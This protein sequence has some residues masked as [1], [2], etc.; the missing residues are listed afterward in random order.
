[1]DLLLIIQLAP[2]L[3]RLVR[4][5]TRRLFDEPPVAKAIST[6]D[7]AFR[8]VEVAPALRRWCESPTFVALLGEVESG[9]EPPTEDDIV[10]SFISASDFYFEDQR[11]TREKAR[12]IVEA[13]FQTLHKNLLGRPEL[14]Y[15]DARTQQAVREG[16]QEIK[17]YLGEVVGPGALTRTASPEASSIEVAEREA[18]AKVDLARGLIDQGKVISAREILVTLREEVHD[19]EPSD[20]LLFRIAANLGACWLSL[21]QPEESEREY[22]LALELRPRD[23]RILAALVRCALQRGDLEKALELSTASLAESPR[24]PHAAATYVLALHRLNRHGELEKFVAENR[25]LFAD[26]VGA[27]TL[28]EIRLDQERYDDA[29]ALLRRALGGRDVD[30]PAARAMLA[31]AIVT[32]IQ[33]ALKLNPPVEGLPEEMDRGLAEGELELS[34]AIDA[35]KDQEVP[36]RLRDAVASR[37]GVRAMRGHLESALD[38]A[39]RVL[40]DDGEHRVALLNRAMVLLRLNKYADAS[41]ELEKL[42]ADSPGDTGLLLLLGVALAG[43]DRHREAVQRLEGIWDPASAD[44]IQAE[45]SDV[46]LRSAWEIRDLAKVERIAGEIRGSAAPSALTKAVLARHLI[47]EDQTEDAIHLLEEAQ[48]EAREQDRSRVNR[49]LAEAYLLSERYV[50]AVRTYSGFVETTRDSASLRSYLAALFN[51]GNY[52]LALELAQGVRRGGKA[53]PVVSEVEA[54]VLQ[55]I[56]DLNS[57]T[58]LFLELAQLE[59]NKVSHLID[60]AGMRLRQGNTEESKEILQSLPFEVI[61]DD[62]VQLLRLAELRLVLGERGVMELAYRARRLDFDNPYTHERYSFLFLNS[63]TLEKELLSVDEVK[64]DSAVRL[65]RGEESRVITVVDDDLTSLARGEVGSDD[66]LAQ[67]LLGK[68]VGDQAVLREGLEDLEYEVVEIQS[69]F[70]A[71]FQETLLN[72]S[73]WFPARYQLQRVEIRENDFSRIFSAIDAR[74]EFAQQVTTLYRTKPATLGVLGSLLG[75]STIDVW[76]GL[77]GMEETRFIVAEGN[78]G[79][80]QEAAAL[81]SSQEQL[82]VDL[83]SILTLAHL[84]LLERLKDRFERVTCPQSLLDT[85][86]EYVEVNYKGATPTG[87]LAKRGTSYIHVEHS[88]EDL[89]KARKHLEG[90]LDF[91]HHKAVVEPVREAL[92]LDPDKLRELGDLIGQDSLDSML[93]AKQFSALLFSDDLRL[94]QLAKGE[95]G[96]DSVWTQPLLSDLRTRGQ[97]TEDEYRRALTHLLLSDYVFISVSAEDLVHTLRAEAFTRSPRSERVLARALGSE[98][99][100]TSAVTAA[101]GVIKVVWLENLLYARK[102]VI[103]DLVLESLTMVRVSRRRVLEELVRALQASLNLL[104]VT[105]AEVVQNIDAWAQAHAL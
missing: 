40:L 5:G 64:V 63:E 60:A 17:Q 56:G 10:E 99:S 87:T 53:I 72:F 13:F 3:I 76:V 82:V 70:V 19:K 34:R 7:S 6:T 78:A 11:Q 92:E 59:S 75:C 46:L 89:E 49:E 58:R 29:E 98:T 54:R 79:E 14:V 69:K 18:Q 33:A 12:E 37:A 32:P 48:S 57:A 26:A 97:L 84:G 8:E 100:L 61:R 103:L 1:M 80:V 31:V 77:V 86:M 66:V 27:G 21:G 30:T 81:L 55:V 23:P 43:S 47:R 28:G 51:A 4:A 41:R 22:R 74:H 73:T 105:F 67:H 95:H 45:I 83:T 9:K 94:R 36:A 96:V 91:L 15:L 93:L 104:P 25:W 52:G 102:T 39:N 65:R 71:A 38:D 24:N 2:E 88:P 101:A 35:Y 16:T 90:I 50:D 44:D 68:R 42:A 20:E 62:P 85:L